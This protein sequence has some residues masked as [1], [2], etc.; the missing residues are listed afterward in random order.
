MLK[1]VS[2]L[3][4]AGRPALP[5]SPEL[6]H[7]LQPQRKGVPPVGRR[8]LLDRHIVGGSVRLAGGCHGPWEFAALWWPGAQSTYTLYS[9]LP[10][11]N[12]RYT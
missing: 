7:T 1:R 6:S 9:P 12:Q 5:L 8:Y 2:P 4:F 3:P 11:V 10:A